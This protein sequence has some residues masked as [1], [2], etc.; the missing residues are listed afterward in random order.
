VLVPALELLE[1]DAW[2]IVAQPAI[3]DDA[4]IVTDM[5]RVAPDEAIVLSEE[6]PMNL[7]SA[8]PS[9]I[10][11]ADG[12]WSG[13]WMSETSFVM[14]CGHA[15]EW[16]FPTTR[17]ALAQGLIAGMPAKVWMIDGEGDVLLMTPTAFADELI[18]RLG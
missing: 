15:I 11:E 7:V 16:A 14:L 3:L 2:R 17:P 5:I 6:S 12:G 13:A 1:L 9:A 8:D 18:E 4:A 10:V